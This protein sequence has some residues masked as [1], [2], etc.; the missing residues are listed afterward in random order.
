MN[1]NNRAQSSSRKHGYFK[2]AFDKDYTTRKS[3][4]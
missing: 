1:S 4:D 3:Q 2:R